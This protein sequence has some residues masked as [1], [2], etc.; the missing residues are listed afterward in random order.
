MKAIVV[1]VDFLNESFA[2]LKMAVIIARKTNAKIV[3][4]FVNKYDR[5]KPVFKT[6]SGKLKQEVEKRFETLI[7]KYSDKLP[8][9]HIEYRI[10]EG[11]RVQQ[12][13]NKE[14][15][16]CQA[17]LIILGTKGDGGFKLFSKSTAFEIVEKAIIP[18][19]TIR[20]GARVPIEI[21][22][23]LIPIDATLETRQKIPFSAHMAKICG[24]EIHLLAMYHSE[25]QT[26]RENVERYTR[27]AAEYLE[28]N[29]IDFIVK[30]IETSDIVN[31]SIKYANLINADI[32]SIMTSQITTISNIWNGSYAEQLIDQCPIP[33][34]TVPSK[35]LI[36]TLSR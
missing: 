19:I 26:V 6:T 33:V 29:Q 28:S 12:V 4:V 2:A 24:A 17:D 22:T 3:L 30:S 21:K 15:E 5:A 36:R 32:I 35:E 18:V 7:K 10:L 1:G 13:I 20:D 14:A 34:I 16:N 31:E 8:A 11:K 9:N 27:Q 23:I 25:V